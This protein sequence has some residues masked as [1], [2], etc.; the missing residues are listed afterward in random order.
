[1]ENIVFVGNEK[2]NLLQQMYVVNKL[3]KLNKNYT[4]YGFRQNNS[5]E[6]FYL[7]GTKTK[8]FCETVAKVCI[9]GEFKPIRIGSA[10]FRY[11]ENTKNLH[12]SYI[13]VKE[14]YRKNGVGDQMLEYIKKYA[15]KVGATSI[16]LDRLCVF[17]NGEKCVTYYGDEYSREDVFKLR[18]EGKPVVDKNLK[19]YE[20][21][22]FIKD[23][24]R[25][26]SETHLVPMVFPKLKPANVSELAIP[27]IYRFRVSK[28]EFDSSVESQTDYGKKQSELSEKEFNRKYTIRSR[29]QL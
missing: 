21:H 3:K 1:M 12:I 17:T 9:K 7:Y 26:P 10:D 11:N 25:R 4:H 5:G 6:Y 15:Q 28:K 13:T 14:K 24:F 20:K 8:V 22:G 27:K 19:F 2:S 29:K 16:T 23:K 18:D